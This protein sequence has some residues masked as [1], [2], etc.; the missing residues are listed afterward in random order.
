MKDLEGSFNALATTLAGRLSGNELLTCSLSAEQSDFVRFNHAR[1]RQAGH[2]EQTYITLRLIDGKRHASVTLTL[3]GD[4]AIDVER[5]QTQVQELR[6]DLHGV[7]DDPML[8]LNTDPSSSRTSRLATLPD[9]R[10]MVDDILSCA[11]TSDMV[12]FIASG[13]LQRGFAN[14]LGQRNWHEATSFQFDWTLYVQA[15]KAV[16]STY[17]GAAWDTGQLARKFA[18]TR[19]ELELLKRP[20]K[21]LE[22]GRYR[23]YL[24]PAAVSDVFG[25]LAWGGFSEKARRTRQSPLQRLA[26]G[27]A[28]LHPCIGLT[29]NVATGFAPPFQPDGFLRPPTIALISA[30]ESAG[31]LIAPRTGREYGLVH[32]GAENDAEMPVSLELSAGTLE[33]SDTLREL[34]RGLYINNLWYLNFSD[35]MKGRLTGMTRFATFWVEAGEVVAPCEVMRFDDSVYRM[36]GKNLCGL[37]RQREWIADT[38]IF[39]ERSTSGRHM[40]GALIDDFQLTL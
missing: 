3:A 6:A 39:T 1:L 7:P 18:K 24:S 34:D 11:G 22:P 9:T 21:R 25:S 33:G 36:L 31:A 28:R 5:C 32:N 27:T 37:T 23:S 4:P 40:P 17:G 38:Y 10:A 20:A 2:V 16:K 13:P 15:D 35:R 14:S 30:G 26:D 12:G 8:L 29:E 19:H